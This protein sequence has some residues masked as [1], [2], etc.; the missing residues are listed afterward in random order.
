LTITKLLAE[1]MGG[2]IALRSEP[3]KGATLRVKLFPARGRQSAHDP[4]GR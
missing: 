3:G 1:S 4:D 2:D